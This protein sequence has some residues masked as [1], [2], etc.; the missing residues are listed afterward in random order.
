MKTA[1]AYTVNRTYILATESNNGTIAHLDLAPMFRN[2]AETH[3][4]KLRQ[5]MPNAPVYVINVNAE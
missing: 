2:Q 1:N 5:L 3:A 4:N